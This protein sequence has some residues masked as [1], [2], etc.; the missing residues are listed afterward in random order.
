M[1]LFNYE[2]DCD[3]N[4]GSLFSK[5]QIKYPKKLNTEMSLMASTYVRF[6]FSLPILFIVFL[7]HFGNF[8]YFIKAIQSA[9]FITY[10]ILASVLQISFT[11]F[12]LYL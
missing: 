10:V 5:C 11:L 8:D 4:T 2:L 6:A 9:D 12:F 1:Y 7:L 3:I